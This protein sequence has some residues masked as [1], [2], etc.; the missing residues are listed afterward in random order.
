M[1]FRK[2]EWALRRVDGRCDSLWQSLSG[3]MST[4]SLLSWDKSQSSLVD[5]TPREEVY[6]SSGCFGGSV[7]RQLREFRESLFL[8]LL[9]FP[10]L[11][12]INVP[13]W[14]ILG[15]HILNFYNHIL[16]VHIWLPFTFS[17]SPDWFRPCVLSHKGSNSNL[18]FWEG[19]TAWG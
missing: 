19:E 10:Q 14:R 8:H 5:E 1:I 15:A 18:N 7:F 6:D 4:S 3:W 12:M 11:K 2:D 16:G 9:F 17:F 13:K